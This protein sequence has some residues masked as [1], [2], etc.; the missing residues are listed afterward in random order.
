MTVAPPRLVS[1]N[2]TRRCNLRCG[3]CYLDARTR[4]TPEG[5]MTTAEGRDLIDQLAE[6]CPGAMLV[7]SGGEPLLRAD[8]PELVSHAAGRGLLP[9]LGTNGALLTDDRAARLVQS[10]LSGVGLSLDSLDQDRHDEFRGAPGS[11]RRAVAAI[12]TCRGRGLPVQIH[13]TATRAN[14]DEIPALMRFAAHRGAVAF[15]LFF[16]VCTGRG[17]DVTDITPHQYETALMA[18]VDAQG[19]YE[20]RMLVRARC[21]PHFRRLLST[22]DA[23]TPTD[24]AAGC[25]AGRTY[26]RVT[27]EGVVTPCPYLPI[28]AGDLRRDTL[29]EIWANAQVFQR[30]R[31]PQLRGRC[32]CCEFGE[33]CGGCRARAFASH[34]DL[35]G[36]DPWCSYHPGSEPGRL[37]ATAPEVEWTAEARARLDRVPVALRAMVESGLLAHARSKGISTITPD[38]MAGMRS[39]GVAPGFATGEDVVDSGSR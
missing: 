1:W 4:S 23:A 32:G 19:A 20:G 30:L 24:A 29:A 37:V 8:L 38:V 11:W 13:T 2:M 27:P 18:L 10:G 5:E 15:N 6:L 33:A 28:E 14:H 31:R 26:C 3:H 25:L 7:L 36:E 12:D 35:M 39:S 34:G 9:V 17:E 21:A 22:H 16:L